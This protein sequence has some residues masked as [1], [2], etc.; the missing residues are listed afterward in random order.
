MNEIN[1]LQEKGM[2]LMAE[3]DRL[4]QEMLRVSNARKQIHNE[5]TNAIGEEGQS[6]ESVTNISNS[7]GPSQDYESSY[8][9]LK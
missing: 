8:A 7:A 1:Y 5:M 2:Q 4:R 9:S 6:S 3:N